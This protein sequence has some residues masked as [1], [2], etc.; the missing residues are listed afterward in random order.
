MDPD[1]P[2]Y[3]VTTLRDVEAGLVGD[4]RLV[5][6]LL[7][8]FGGLALLLAMTGIWGV[9]AYEVVRRRREIGIRLSLGA[10]S[11]Q[12]VRL[13]LRQGLV[14]MALGVLA[15]CVVA[16]LA[17]RLLTSQLYEVAPTDPRIFLATSGVVSLVTLAA[18]LFPARRASR[19][20]PMAALR[21]E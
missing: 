11:G 5:M 20:D 10:E 19:V 12:V 2:I 3:G 15:G 1:L 21:S 16:L 18:G 13:V 6:S 7:I 9:V 17:A 14:A 8:G 4:R